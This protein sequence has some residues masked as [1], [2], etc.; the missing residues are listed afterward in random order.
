MLHHKLIAG[1]IPGTYL[2]TKLI[3]EEVL[4]SRA[5]RGAQ[6]FCIFNQRDQ[7]ILPPVIYYSKPLFS[8]PIV[9]WAI[10]HTGGRHQDSPLNNWIIQ[11]KKNHQKGGSFINNTLSG[12]RE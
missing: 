4:T 5:R 8:Q 11:N 10:H 9:S 3:N 2:V 6:P 1:E 7:G 12:Y